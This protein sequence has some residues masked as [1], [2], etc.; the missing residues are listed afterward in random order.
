MLSPFVV[1]KL[2][3]WGCHPRPAEHLSYLSCIGEHSHG[4]QFQEACLALL[5]SLSGSLE[6]SPQ[7]EVAAP[8]YTVSL[9]HQQVLHLM[10]QPATH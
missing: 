3:F 1:D 10:I 8:V 7:V 4:A 6:P 5:S 9:L 2:Q